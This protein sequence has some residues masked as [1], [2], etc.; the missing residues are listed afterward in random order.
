MKRSAVAW[1]A[2]A[3]YIAVI[4]LATLS[5]LR[6]DFDIT[7]ATPRLERAFE[8]NLFGR[9]VVDGLR[10]VA[11]FA[12]W[13]V[14]WV[15]TAPGARLMRAIGAATA[16]GALLSA[17]VEATQLL[18]TTRTASFLDVMTN[19]GGALAGAVA[20]VLAAWAVHEKRGARSF[21]GIPAFV[22][23]GAYLAAAGLEAFI[24]LFRQDAL[25]G[26]TGGP[27]ARLSHALGEFEWSSLGVLPLFDGVLFA[28]AG[29][30]SVAALVERGFRYWAAAR[31]VMIAG[32]VV[33]VG[34]ELARGAASQPIV[35]GPALV[36]AATI[37]LGAAAAARWLPGLS[38][39]LRGAA[40]PQVFLMVYTL[41]LVLWAWRPLV[42]EL[43][44]SAIGEQLSIRRLIPLTALGI[45][46]DLFSVV[47]VVR[48]FCLLVPVGALLAVWPLRR[49]GWLRGPLPAVYLAFALEAG[50][51]L[52]IG[53]FFDI[54]DAL[55]GSAGVLIGWTLVRRSGYPTYG[56]ILK[57]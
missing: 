16:T 5:R 7:Q 3:A 27:I 6:P 36:H 28:P 54:T 26:G 40:R 57:S 34:V 10:N 8:L 49:D 22:F 51:I 43:S 50:Q 46:V 21:I 33:F 13:G 12:G 32:T 29:A 24:P 52:V 18:S 41:W 1:A 15:A 37:A 14:V 4:L 25:V 20:V 39:N 2:R 55:I 45:R 48:Q 53:R 42:P 19:T 56:T 11:L 35:A 38:R 9:D 17:I 47:D 44:L 23:A 31:I 30:L